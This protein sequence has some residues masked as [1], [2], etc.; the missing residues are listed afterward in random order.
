M[1]NRFQIKSFITAAFFLVAYLNVFATQASCNLPHFFEEISKS[2]QHQNGSHGHHH[3]DKKSP[4]HH[5][6]ENSSHNKKGAEKDSNCCNDKTT[7][8]F[9]NQGNHIIYSVDFKNT[10]F[11]ELIF[12]NALLDNNLS[13]SNSNCAISYSLPPPKIPDIRVFI[14]SFII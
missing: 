10:F 9:A 6:D 7:T 3:D 5:N 8:F 14:Q 12:A 11:T 1:K 4:S 13:L 2:T